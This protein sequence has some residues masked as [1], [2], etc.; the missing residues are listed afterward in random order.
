MMQLNRTEFSDF[1][2]LRHITQDAPVDIVQIGNGAM[3]G[4][5]SHLALGTIGVATGTYTRGIRLRGQLSE[6]RWAFTLTGEAGSAWVNH[7]EARAGDQ[8]ITP[9]GNE[10][11]FVRE[12]ANTYAVALIEP[13]E[14]LD[15][16]ES[17]EPGAADAELLC[18][19]LPV[20]QETAA[21]RA[22]SFQTIFTGLIKHGETMSVEAREF[23]RR[24]IME[25]ATGPTLGNVKHK[26]ARQRRSAASLVREVDHFTDAMKRPIHISELCEV[27][28]VSRRG[29]HRA[30]HDAMGTPVIHFLR[31][32][33]L[34]YVHAALKRGGHVLVRDVAREHGFLEQGKFAHEYQRLFGELPHVTLVNARHLVM[35][36]ALW[37]IPMLLRCSTLA[38]ID[39]IDI[40]V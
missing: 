35:V 14:L 10:L 19:I 17:Q 9:P 32:K 1:E 18:P 8:I 34:C 38:L 37:W 6:R 15:F 20:D 23:Y 30:F 40:I 2:A 25:L 27:F 29:L 5:I 12:H 39:S 22:R 33:R 31:H 28:K 36:I 16:L 21:H 7:A 24:N 13:D 4:N 26:T 3:S 11:Y